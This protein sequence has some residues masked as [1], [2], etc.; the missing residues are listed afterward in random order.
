[1]RLKFDL[2]INNNNHHK[3]Y[4][5]RQYNEQYRPLSFIKAISKRPFPWTKTEIKLVISEKMFHF[6]RNFYSIPA[7]M[8][9]EN[10]TTVISFFV[11]TD[12][13]A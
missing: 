11:P 6:K 4:N 12:T 2:Y 1:V 3:P 9:T 8:P 10:T 7:I 5:S 13:V